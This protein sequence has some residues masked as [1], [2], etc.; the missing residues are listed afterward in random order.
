MAFS[1]EQIAAM[2]I[3]QN[4]GPEFT[5]DKIA[6]EWQSSDD[7]KSLEYQL[8]EAVNYYAQ[9]INTESGVD[10]KWRIDALAANLRGRI[11]RNPTTT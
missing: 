6:S 2:I 8:T 5:A 9:W 3:N 7:T 10:E 11:R 4:A 1:L